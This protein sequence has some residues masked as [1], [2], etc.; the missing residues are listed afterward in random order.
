MGLP[1]EGPESHAAGRGVARALIDY[2]LRRPQLRL[3]LPLGLLVGI[4]LSLINQG[5][6]IFSGRANLL[7]VCLTCSPNFLVPFVALNIALLIAA[8][9]ARRRGL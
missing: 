5:S 4:A 3:T 9:V 6:M 2:C 1:S 8:P 7:E